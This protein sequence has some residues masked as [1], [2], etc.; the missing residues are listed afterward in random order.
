MK[1]Q[2]TFAD[3]IRMQN[4]IKVEIKVLLFHVYE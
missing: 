4:S 1:K 2:L 3:K